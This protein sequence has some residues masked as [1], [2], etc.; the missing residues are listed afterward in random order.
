[1]N[2]RLQNAKLNRDYFIHNVL[3]EI[4]RN[5]IVEDAKKCKKKVH[6]H[7]DNAPSH[8]YAAVIEYF[9]HSL[10]SMVPHPPYSQDLS[11]CDFGLFGT[12]YVE[13]KNCSFETEDELIKAVINFCESK[14]SDFWEKIFLSWID[15]LKECINAGGEYFE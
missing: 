10:M 11:P 13:F 5:E 6:F 4:E 8:N 1:M 14:S 2:V 15:R 12:I 3:E 9:T 7:F